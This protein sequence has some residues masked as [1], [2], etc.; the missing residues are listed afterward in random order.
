MSV[1]NIL[2]LMLATGLLCLGHLGL[3]FWLSQLV[4]SQMSQ[5]EFD[6]ILGPL[7][8]ARAARQDSQGLREAVSAPTVATEVLENQG[9]REAA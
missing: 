8:A 4:P 7:V 3:G 5:E 6:R 1:T 2:L 9:R